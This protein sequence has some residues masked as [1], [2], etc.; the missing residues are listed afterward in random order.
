VVT[1][2]KDSHLKHKD[3]TACEKDDYVKAQKLEAEI[4]RQAEQRRLGLK[5]RLEEE[6]SMKSIDFSKSTQMKLALEKCRSTKRMYVNVLR[7]PMKVDTYVKVPGMDTLK[8][9]NNVLDE[10]MIERCQDL[11]PW[12]EHIELWVWYLFHLRQSFQDWSMVSCYFL[13]LLL[14]D[15]MPLF[16]ATD[17]IYPLAWRDV[18]QAF[19][20][21]N[22]PKRHWS[23]AQFHI[24]CNKCKKVGH[25]ARN[26]WSSGPNGINNNRGNSET[27]QNAVTF[28]ECGVHG[29][30]KK[31]CPKLKNGNRGNQRG[32]GNAPAKVY[33]VGNAGTNPDSNVV[34]ELGSFD[35]IIDMGWLSK[36]HAVIDCA[37]KIVCI[38]WGNETLLVHGHRVFLAHVTTK[39]TE[40]KSGEKRLEDVPIV[41]DFPK[42]F[43][44]ELPSLPPTRQVEFQIDLM[45][46]VAPVARAPYRL[47]P[48]KMKELEL[49]KLTVKNRYLLPRID[50]L[51][52]QLQG[53]S[54]YSKIDLKS[55]YHQLRV[56]DG[57]IPKMEFRTRYGHYKFQVMPFGL[58]NEPAVFMDLMNQVCKPYLDNFVIVF[59]DDILI[60]S[61]DKKEHEEHLKAILELLNK[62]ELY[63][64][65]SK[66]L[67]GYYRRF[68]KGFSKV[69][70]PMTKLTQKKVTFELGDKQEVAFQTL[71]DKLCS[72]PILALPQGAENFIV[73]CDASH[74][75]GMIRKDIPK[76]KLE[77]RVD[78]TLCLNGRSW[79]PCYG[80]LRT[81]I[82][83][84]SYKSKY[85]VHPGSDKMY[86]DMKKLYW[87]PNMKANITTYV[88]KCLAYAKVKAKH[89]RP[90][91][92]L[93]ALGTSL[94]MSTAYH[95]EIDG[96]SERTIQNLEDIL[97]AC[98]I[99]FRNG[100]V[101]HLP[102]IEFSYNNSYHASIKA[103]PFKALYRRKCRSPVCWV[104]VR[105][106]QLTGPEMNNTSS[107]WIHEM[108]CE[109][110]LALAGVQ[111]LTNDG[112]VTH[113]ET[114]DEDRFKMVFIAFG[115][116][117]RSF[118]YHMRSLIIIDA[119]HLKGTY[120]GTN[121][122]AAGIDGNNQII[123]IVTQ[124]EIDPLWTWFL[125][126][127]KECIGPDVYEKLIEAGVERWSRAYFLNNH[128][129]Y[130]TSNSVES[131]NAIVG[132]IKT[133]KVY[134]VDD[135]RKIHTVELCNNT[136]TCRKLQVSGLPCGHVL[137]ICRVLGLTDC[138]HLAKGWF[139][140][141]MLKA[142]HQGLL[143]HVEEV[144]TW[145]SPNY[146][147]V[148][149]PSLMD[150]RPSGRPKST[151]H[152]RSQGEELIQVTCGRCGSRG[153]N[154]QACRKTIP[155]KKQAEDN[156][157]QAM[158]F[159]F[160]AVNLDYL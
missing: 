143:Y 48:S 25:L 43:S 12:E 88:S 115:V 120:L 65:F 119:T 8:K 35:V 6:N 106:A 53:S 42:V 67:A 140:R 150:K 79:L 39:E 95:S 11:K 49:N 135:R 157:Q 57:D 130:M 3:S 72:A 4:N 160:E 89:Q 19:I 132:E 29:Y 134:Q 133:Y 131:I 159:S 136:C 113:I 149:K 116:A 2:K 96:Q 145:H 77:P 109:P 33:V 40:D 66:C 38:P 146:L 69:A 83:H 82:M 27:T 78:G 87:W 64:K 84:E 75:G 74:K 118:T 14:L 62:E 59:I 63:A 81:M 16:Y 32:N 107:G 104:E 9:Q 71:K 52:D 156:S 127:L 46:S 93:K 22:E 17:E 15:S 23:L 34:T 137:V 1:N 155:K 10:F 31:D 86:E 18:E 54:V 50:D 148:V 121:L 90:S 60:Y 138:N 7:P 158:L 144:S 103:A 55:G 110:G 142:M 92:L 61:K 141:T 58:T 73:Y 76:E 112:P 37:E 122:L 26:C 114:D 139:W 111:A 126:K 85:S 100:W 147:Q 47:A 124:G 151:N 5:L 101:K 28:Y 94:D 97:R 108:Y 44:K 128:Y 125:S 56:H 20:P 154:R 129:N 68:I 80:D 123:P 105:Q 70:K 21:I 45:P 36:Y 99:D 153:H 98:V 102:L 51:F 30:F 91:R 117:N 13:T 24:K 41:R 152:I